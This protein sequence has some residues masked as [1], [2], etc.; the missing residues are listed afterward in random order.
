ADFNH[1]GLADV[2]VGLQNGNVGV[3]FGA[4]TLPFSN[5]FVAS[6]PGPVTALVTGDFNNDGNADI[7]AVRETSSGTA[8]SIDYGNG[9]GAF[10]PGP[11]ITMSAT[12]ATGM[13]AADFLGTGQLGLAIANFTNNTI[14][15]VLNNGD[16]T[17]TPRVLSVL[18]NPFS[19]V[20]A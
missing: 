19:L 13:V 2:A 8:L 12:R 9:Q 10:S 15:V 20:A 17:F 5:Q 6:G 16:G 11:F 7:A 18:G 4:R 14:T 3:I 1:D